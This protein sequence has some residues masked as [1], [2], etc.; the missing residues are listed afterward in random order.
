MELKESQRLNIISRVQS[1]LQAEHQGARTQL[2]VNR[3]RLNFACPYCGDSS[4]QYKKR[5][6]VYFKSLQFHCYNDGCSKRH[7]DLV[8][9]FRDF[10]QQVTNKEDLVYYLDYIQTN[11]VV[12]PTQDYLEVG[13]FS[14]IIKSAIPLD[15]IKKKFNLQTADENFR[16]QR[17]LKGRFMHK[18]LDHFMYDP[19]KEQ[20]YIF[21]LTPDKLHAVGWQIRNFKPGKAKYISYNLEKINQLVLDKPI[22]LPNEELIKMNTLSL[23]FGL[24]HVNFES[25][26]TVFEGPIDSLLY[27]NSIAIAG[28]DKP[29]LMFDDI[30]TVRY[31]FDNDR[32]G[33]IA[34]ESKL[35]R[36]KKVF[37]WNKLVRDFKIR[38]P[39]KDFNELV[40]YC[41]KQKNDAVKN[42]ENYFTENPLDIRSV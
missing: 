15:V 7:T 42:I 32:P 38:K 6:N 23:Y 37:M 35:K 11:R 39:V 8:T 41:W 28:L 13:V 4:D 27:S 16:I 24:M 14:N 9:F 26:V 20:L 36:R 29:T 12:I 31:L 30:S 1:I 2:K 5:G 21:N 10:N 33:R 3:D 40:D 17:Y 25:P 19:F 18:K 34:M 22:D